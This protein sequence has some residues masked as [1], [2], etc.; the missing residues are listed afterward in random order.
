MRKITDQ[1]ATSAGLVARTLEDE[2]DSGAAFSNGGR[3][4][5]RRIFGLVPIRGAW[6]EA[7][8]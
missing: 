6:A 2:A 3:Q 4:G 8:E 5:V 1:T 7:G